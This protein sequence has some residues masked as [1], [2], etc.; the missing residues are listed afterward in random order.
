MAKESNQKVDQAKRPI[1]KRVAARARTRAKNSTQGFVDFIRTQ[2]VVGLAIGF[3]IGAQAKSLV[4]QFSKSFV[5]PILGLVIGTSQ[6]LSNQVFYLTIGNETAQFTWGAFVYALINFMVVALV[7]Y[8]VFKI[9]RL[10]KLDKK[11]D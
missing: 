9:M 5:D 6:G 11:K 4:D 10:D 3:I 2:G 7:V 1:R 8:L